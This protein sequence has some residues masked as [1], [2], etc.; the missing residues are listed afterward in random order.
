MK[1]KLVLFLSVLAFMGKEASCVSIN[2]KNIDNI[3]YVAFGSGLVLSSF[4]ELA[5]NT[6]DYPCVNSMASVLSNGYMSIYYYFL[7]EATKDYADMAML[8]AYAAQ[9]TVSTESF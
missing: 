8:V 5:A 9:L 1:S 7:Y 4:I 2:T 6:P 3:D